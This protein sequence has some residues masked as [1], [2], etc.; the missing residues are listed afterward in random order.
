MIIGTILVIIG[1]Y[2]VTKGWNFLTDEHNV[3][4]DSM[5]SLGLIMIPIGLVLVVSFTICVGLQI[6]D[7]ITCYTFPEKMVLKELIKIKNQIG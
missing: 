5:I 3:E 2:L 1:V 4:D 6:F 7:I